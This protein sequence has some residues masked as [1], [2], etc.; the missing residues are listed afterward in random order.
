MYIS[1]YESNVEKKKKVGSKKNLT[2]I[3]NNTQK[4]RTFKKNKN[5]LIKFKMSKSTN[6]YLKFRNSTKK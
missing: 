1:R 4:I 6:F 3:S 5:F 2:D